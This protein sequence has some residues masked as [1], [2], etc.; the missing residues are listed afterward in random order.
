MICSHCKFFKKNYL[1][2]HWVFFLNWRIIALQCCV[3][4]C[5]KQF[6][7]AVLCIC[8]LPLEPPSLFPS[9]PSTSSQSARLGFLFYMAT[10]YQLSILHMVVYICQCYLLTSQQWCAGSLQWHLG[11]SLVV[12][13]RLSCPKAC[14]ILVPRPGIQP[15]FPALKGGFLTTGPPGKS[16]L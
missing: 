10:S 7:S 1:C 15:K 2:L 14:G 5:L 6:E 3:G 9:H 12:A 13:H 8:P 16:P 4:F 11:F